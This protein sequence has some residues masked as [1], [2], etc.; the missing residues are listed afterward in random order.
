M[1]SRARFWLGLFIVTGLY[2]LHVN[3]KIQKIYQNSTWNATDEVG[4]FWS[5]TA[6]HYRFVKYFATHPVRD[7]HQ[8]TQDRAV[9]YPDTINDWAEFT[10][11]MEVP[12]GLLYRW[13]HPAL[14]LHVFV[15]WYAC[16]VS[17]LTLFAVFLLAR[18][19]WR[20]AAAG[21][22]GSILYA[23]LYPSYGRTVKNL[24]LREDFA[25]PLIV[26]ALFFSLCAL[27]DRRR[28][29]QICAALFW[30][31]ALASWHLTQFV[32]AVGVGAV[33]LIY[34]GQGTAPR[35]P[36][37]VLV[38]AAGSVGIPVLW[39][40]QFYLSVTMCVLFAL[41]LTNW[42]TSQRKWAPLVFG[43][44][45]VLLLAISAW[46][47]QSYSE[48]A[49]VYQLLI[50]KLRYLGVKP[51]NPADL[52]WE[53]RCLWQGAFDTA[54]AWEFWHSLQWC[55][56]L[57]VVAAWKMGQ[58]DIGKNV[59]VLFTLLLVPLTWMVIRYFTFLGFA[60]AVVAAGLA[61]QQLRW[62]VVL[63]LATVWQ[64]AL[65]NFQPLSRAPV[66]P[67]NNRPLMTWISTQTPTNAVILA[68]I[69]EAPAVLAY[70]GRSIIL[71]SK[72]ENRAIRERYREFLTAIY[73]TEEQFYDFARRYGAD[74]FI[75]DGDYL[76]PGPTSRRY[77]ADKLGN[78]DQNC[79][80]LLFA[81]APQQL[82]HFQLV[83]IAGGSAIFRVLPAAGLGPS[84]TGR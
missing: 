83:S 58:R 69:S 2:V 45:L 1:T 21:V 74:Y 53:A 46:R 51:T 44:W 40:K 19:L 71:H 64:I 15:V 36:W 26:F 5:E 25:I 24:F 72:F 43:G 48:Y 12:V 41:A 81:L 55:L 32:L 39:A 76:I 56:P 6:F 84:L 38:L 10:V 68:T 54:S 23:T 37:F 63:G 4:Q 33:V 20:N 65:L 52:P 60:V 34:F 27:R 13:L 35:V 42:I 62:R 18:E 31:A 7:W 8:L 47:Q 49:H 30:L 3:L 82:Q 79:T 17:S 16:L 70:T 57:A 50:S 61:T 80:A 29:D 14:P 11:A 59:L 67:D 73:G 66:V 9:Q 22:F 75:Y 77:Q 78:L 28:S